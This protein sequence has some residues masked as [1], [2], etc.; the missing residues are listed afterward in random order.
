M[1]IG[2]R[3]A[4]PVVRL[5]R[6]IFWE[7]LT[8]RNITMAQFALMCEIPSCNLSR[9]VN[10]RY[11]LTAKMRAK[12]LEGTRRAGSPLSFDELFVIEESPPEEGHS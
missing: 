1:A 11:T 8:R 5:K 7:Y 12:I 9:L 10:G 6:Q 4:L 3:R 2:S